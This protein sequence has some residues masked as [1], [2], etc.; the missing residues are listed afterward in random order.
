MSVSGLSEQLS[1]LLDANS[2]QMGEGSAFSLMLATVMDIKD[3]KNLNRVRCLPIGAPDSEMTDWCY[4][5][6]PMGGK[7]QG[8]FLF[9]QVGDLVVL[10]FLK[11]DPHRPIVLGSFWNSESKAPVAVKNGKAED[12]C[13]KTP[14]KVELT[15]HDEK[16]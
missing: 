6:T 5:M 1:V 2:D 11:N 15:L 12:Y 14:Q 7:D 3:E 4:V 9:P 16:K 13:L 8:L 10:G